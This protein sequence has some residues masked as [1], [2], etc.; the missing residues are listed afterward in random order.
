MDDLPGT[1]AL[2]GAP[3]GVGTRRVRESPNTNS[4]V[5]VVAV[6]VVV[7]VA[8]AV[9]E[10]VVVVVVVGAGLDRV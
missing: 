9:V 5:V 4:L 10:V 6:V 8:A 2:M 3:R 1:Q 7:V